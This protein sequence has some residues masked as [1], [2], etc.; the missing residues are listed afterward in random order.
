MSLSAAPDV[1]RSAYA[2]LVVTDLAKARWFWVDMLGFHVQHEDERSLYLRGT[3][4]LTHH[5]FVLRTGDTAALDHLAYR[6][7]TPRTSTG[8]RRSSPGSAARSAAFRPAKDGVPWCA[9]PLRLAVR[10]LVKLMNER[11]GPLEDPCGVEP[12]D[13][14]TGGPVGTEYCHAATHGS[15]P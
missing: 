7:R 11:T 6:V 9:T 10:L 8:S 14:C 12:R 2:Q 1:V 5:S 3:D 13:R 15:R 4:E